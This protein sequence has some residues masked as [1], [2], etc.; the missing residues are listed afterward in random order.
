MT[1]PS[2][3][4]SFADQARPA[5][6][7][8]LERTIT[9]ADYSST[10]ELLSMITYQLGWSGDDAGKK[11]QGKQLRGLFCLLTCQA[12]GG[13]W[14]AALP[15]AAAVEL[16]HNFS[17]IHD[18]IEDNSDIRRGRPTVWK[19]WGEAQAINTGD[20]IF[21]LANASLLNLA[22]TISLE[23]TLKASTL[24]QTTCLQLT[25]GQHLDIAFEDLDQVSI[26]DYFHMISRKTAALIA[27]C[28]QVG[29]LCAGASQAIQDHY[30]DFGRCLGLAFQV[31]D[32]ILGIWG[33]E[34]RTGKSTSG[35]L[36]T[37]KKTLPV[38]F[39]LQ[40][41]KDFYKG[42]I[43]GE[44]TPNKVRQ[45]SDLLETEGGLS[46]AQREAGILTGEAMVSLDKAQP[47]GEAGKILRETA[48]Q[49]LSRSV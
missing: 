49:L 3:I 39:G 42:W 40:Q 43:S 25:Q 28:F 34:E 36:V 17:L 38:I 10:P 21:A 46:Y 41:K 44:M 37:R 26:E 45:L 1:E 4:N 8:E 47:H 19:I 27:F 13:N 20:A 11:A 5:L 15:A 14:Q 2:A 9:Q 22:D 32:D 33:E 48:Q 35:D 30:Y 7:K 6:R 12:A 29:A 23:A 24:F 31:M 16:L 18:D